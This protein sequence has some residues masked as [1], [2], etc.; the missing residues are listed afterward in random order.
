MLGYSFFP[1]FPHQEK[2]SQT[3]FSHLVKKKLGSFFL[4]GGSKNDNFS[5]AGC[6]MIFFITLSRSF[7][8]ALG[9]LVFSF[10]VLLAVAGKLD[11][12]LISHCL[13]ALEKRKVGFMK[14]STSNISTRT[15]GF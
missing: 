5:G 9:D 6:S 8:Q 7:L 11:R 12:H 3:N 13:T 14:N 4:G 15:I 10:V 1:V 2:K